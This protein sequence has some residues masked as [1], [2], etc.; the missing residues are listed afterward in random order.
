MARVE[1]LESELIAE[2]LLWRPASERD[3]AE[4]ESVHDEV[5]QRAWHVVPAIR[6]KV[7]GVPLTR[8]QR[9]LRNLAVHHPATPIRAMTGLGGQRLCSLQ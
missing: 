3:K 5:S 6:A 1:Q 2:R 8:R 4:Q 7:L 9:L